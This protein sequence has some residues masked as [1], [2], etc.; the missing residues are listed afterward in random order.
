MKVKIFYEDNYEL[1][2]EKING[3]LNHNSNIRIVNITQ[4]QDAGYK[5]D[6]GVFMSGTIFIA[7]WYERPKD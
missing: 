5:N 6:Y 4:S 1:L 3:W 2:E 7:I